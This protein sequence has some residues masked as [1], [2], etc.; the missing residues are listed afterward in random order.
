MASARVVISGVAL[1]LAAIRLIHAFTSTASTFDNA[2]GAGA[3]PT[4]TQ[5]QCVTVAVDD[6]RTSTFAHVRG[7]DCARS[8][9]HVILRTGSMNGM[10]SDEASVVAAVR[11]AAPAL[12]AKGDVYWS[13]A[14][15]ILVDTTP[16]PQEGLG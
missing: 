9:A 10:T 2:S 11:K 7:T 4:Y 6:A 12:A 13:S 15:W 14:Q 1:V 3:T 16:A 5:G 8:D